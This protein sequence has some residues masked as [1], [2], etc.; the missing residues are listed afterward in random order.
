M[1][2]KHDNSSVATANGSCRMSRDIVLVVTWVPQVL[3]S[4]RDE[5]LEPFQAD[6]WGQNV[7][8]LIDELSKLNHIFEM[9]LCDPQHHRCRCF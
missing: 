5:F 8:L 6:A 9:N 4:S 1:K 7:V 2:G 3:V